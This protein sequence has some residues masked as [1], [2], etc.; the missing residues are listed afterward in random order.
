MRA[1][2]VTLA[3]EELSEDERRAVAGRML[4]YYLYCADLADGLLPITR[5]TVEISPRSCRRRS[6]PSTPPRRPW[7]WLER[8]GSTCSPPPGTPSRHGLARA[9]LAAAYTLSRLFWLLADRDSWLA[10][11]EA[12]IRA[13]VR[14]LR[15]RWRSS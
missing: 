8:S 15:I 4:D 1:Y 2:C 11:H 10:T 14:R 9:R 13:C 7:T 5:G 3:G 6:P 12:A